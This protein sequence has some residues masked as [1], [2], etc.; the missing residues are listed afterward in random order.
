MYYINQAKF[1]LL[2]DCNDITDVGLHLEY[3]SQ[4]SR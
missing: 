1:M 3:L 4:I 2:H